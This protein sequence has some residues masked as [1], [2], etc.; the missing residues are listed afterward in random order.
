VFEPR[1][2]FGE[3]HLFLR[4]A[5]EQGISR[6]PDPFRIGE[7]P[8]QAL[9][10]NRKQLLVRQVGMVFAAQRK[11]ARTSR[12]ENSPS[13]AESV[14]LEHIGCTAFTYHRLNGYGECPCDDESGA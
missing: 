1:F 7:F 2:G 3:G 11:S 13:V 6:T 4:Y 14:Q 8:S 5:P 10:E 9:P 12:S